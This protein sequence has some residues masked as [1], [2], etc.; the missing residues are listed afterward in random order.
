MYSKVKDY[1][2]VNE[3]LS[4][5]IESLVGLKQGEIMSPL[6]FALFIDYIE[7]FS[8]DD[9]ACGLSRKYQYFAFTFC[10]WYGD[11]PEGLQSS[12]DKLYDYCMRWGLEV[13]TEKSKIDSFFFFFSGVENVNYTFYFN[14]ITIIRCLCQL[15]SLGYGQDF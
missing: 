4:L 12:L 11:N 13:N 1:V 3:I 7:W 8:Q 14:T 9:L 6:L 15:Y 5:P 2:K 10:R